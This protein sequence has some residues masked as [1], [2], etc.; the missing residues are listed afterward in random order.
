MYDLSGLFS[1]VLT[2]VCSVRREWRCQRP[3]LRGAERHPHRHHGLHRAGRLHRH[4]V[5]PDVGRVRV[6]E[7]GGRQHQ[8]QR[9]VPVPRARHG[10]HQH[11]VSHPREG[12]P[13]K[14]KSSTLLST[15]SL[16]RMYPP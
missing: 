15:F 14:C 2:C 6:G 3:Q 13:F 1:P 8:H 11:E 16:R 5:P 10:H 7:Q 4:G 9:P 12:R